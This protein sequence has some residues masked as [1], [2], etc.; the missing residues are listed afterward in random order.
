[1]SAIKTHITFVVMI[2]NMTGYKI[3]VASIFI[4]DKIHQKYVN[5]AYKIVD[6]DGKSM[7]T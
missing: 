3:M 2:A 5:V 6:N 1:M 7:R 4:R